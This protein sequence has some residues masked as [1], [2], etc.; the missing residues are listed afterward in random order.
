[1]AD[2]VAEFAGSSSCSVAKPLT[3]VKVK[4]TSG[5]YDVSAPTQTSTA[6]ESGV[7]ITCCRVD[8]LIDW[9]WQDLC[10]VWNE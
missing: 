6:M 2:V 5:A 8:L 7:N 1:M 4:G 10:L 3:A 9:L